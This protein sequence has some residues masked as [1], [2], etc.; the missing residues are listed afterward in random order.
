MD[1]DKKD[2][3]RGHHYDGIQ[4]YDNSLP[5]WWLMTFFITIAFAGYY[6]Y[7]FQIL[8]TGPSQ[9]AEYE[10]SMALHQQMNPQQATGE[11]TDDSIMA[12][13]KDSAIIADGKTTFT[14]YCVVCHGANAEGNIGPNLT[15]KYWLHGSKPTMMITTVTEGVPAKGMTPWKGLLSPKQIQHVVAYAI[16]LRGTNPANPKAPQGDPE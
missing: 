4:E 2:Q 6:W 7:N 10:Q 5:N 1:D 13:T 3:V 14:T 9:K 8:K 15:D 12:M 16:T 11:V